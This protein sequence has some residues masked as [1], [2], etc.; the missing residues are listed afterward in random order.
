MDA[1]VQYARKVP[2]GY[3]MLKPEYHARESQHNE[4]LALLAEIGKGLGFKI[5]IGRKEQSEFADG[6]AGHK[7]LSEYVNAKLDNI[8]NAENKKTIQG[9]D[10]LWIKSNKIISSFEVEFSTSMTSG[11]VRG[12]NIDSKVSKYLV[13]P[14]EREEQFRRKQRSPMFAERFQNDNWNLLFFDAVRHHYKKLKSKEI[15]LEKIVNK[16]GPLAMRPEKKSNT[17]LNLF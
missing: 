12:S 6:L 7:K 2:G 10:L 3:W 11:L 14:E 15:E 9:I 13:I 1:L 16:K 17:Q 4:V 8:T 5:W